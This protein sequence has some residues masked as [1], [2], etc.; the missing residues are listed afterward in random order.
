MLIHWSG[1]AT[2][3]K[4]VSAVMIAEIILAYL[5]KGY[6]DKRTILLII[7]ISS[8]MML[9]GSFKFKNNEDDNE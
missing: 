3:I 1:I 2:V 5:I 4:A 7:T 9:V 8:L 6:S